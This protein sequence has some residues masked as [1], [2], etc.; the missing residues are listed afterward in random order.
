MTFN[1]FLQHVKV[2]RMLY[3]VAAATYFY[4]RNIDYYYGLNKN[5]LKKALNKNK[6]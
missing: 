3:G 5:E 6:Q 4:E 1:E 2:L